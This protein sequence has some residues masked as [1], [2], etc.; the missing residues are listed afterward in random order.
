MA[1]KIKML[2]LRRHSIKDGPDQ[3][4]GPKGLELAIRE[5]KRVDLGTVPVVGPPVQEQDEM[6]LLDSGQTAKR[7]YD[8]LF[9]GPQ[10]QNAQTALAFCQGL[11][12]VPRVMPIVNGL[13]NDNLF[14]EI[15]TEEFKAAVQSGL[16][17]F[18]AVRQVHCDIKVAAWADRGRMAVTRMFDEMGDG[19]IGAGFFYGIPIELAAWACGAGDDTVKEWTGLREAEGLIFVWDPGATA[20]PA[21]FGKIA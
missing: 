12:Y 1:T 17:N 2:H 21:V 20:T 18:A 3:T 14:A 8:K 7:R 16:S 11:G 10:V 15:I 13:G 5:G 6:A 9:H 4:I 19:E